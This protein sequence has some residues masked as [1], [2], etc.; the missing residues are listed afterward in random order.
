M[1]LLVTML[2]A[3]LIISAVIAA[4]SIGVI[5]GR[6]PIKGSCGGLNGHGCELCSG[7][8]SRSTDTA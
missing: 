8:C 3:F 4:M 6:A 5:A 7:K 1:M 2:L